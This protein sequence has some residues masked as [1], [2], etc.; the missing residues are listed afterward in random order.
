MCPINLIHRRF[1]VQFLCFCFCFF[2]TFFCFCVVIMYVNAATM[3]P[4]F[5]LLYVS[6][7][8]VVVAM[9]MLLCYANV[10][11]TMCLL[12]LHSHQT[13]THTHS[14]ST[15]CTK[16]TTLKALHSHCYNS[17]M[18]SFL[19]WRLLWMK[20]QSQVRFEWENSAKWLL[21]RQ[22]VLLSFEVFPSIAFA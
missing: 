9:L 2:A 3:M 6:F 16:L 5:L 7:V 22:Y 21:L 15:Q 18:W 17:A 4:V 11:A 12:P 1:Y 13:H 19:Y 8:V 20:V 10:G 14:N